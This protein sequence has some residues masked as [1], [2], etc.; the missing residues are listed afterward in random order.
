MYYIALKLLSREP[1]K[2]MNFIR[3][4]AIPIILL[5]TVGGIISSVDVQLTNLLTLGGQNDVLIVRDTSVPIEKSIVSANLTKNLPRSNIGKIIPFLFQNLQITINDGNKTFDSTVPF[6]ATNLT[7]LESSE[8]FRTVTNSQLQNIT[9]PSIIIGSQLAQMLNLDIKTNNNISIF[10]PVTNQSFIIALELD[11]PDPYIDSFIIDLGSVQMLNKSFDGSYYSQLMIVVKDKSKMI[12]TEDQIQNFLDEF[13]PQSQLT[14]FQGSGTSFLLSSV[15]AKIVEQL[16][17]FNF[18]LDVLIITRIV[19]VLLWIAQ[20]YQYE[21][22]QLKILGTNRFQIYLIF[23]LISLVI[24]NFGIILGIFGSIFLP[25][26]LTYVIA[27]ITLQPVNI[28]LPTVIQILITFFEMNILIIAVSLIPS[29]IL[30]SKKILSQKSR[31]N[32]NL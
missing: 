11:N 12:N 9:G 8:P 18:I 24:G 21:L 5:L 26:I 6:I 3:D 27:I 32:I 29:Y 31:E 4:I 28:R 2:T 10:V 15:L 16:R 22:N 1:K 30:T 14:V 20:D 25:P 7:S 23:I 19:Q 17:I 13:Y